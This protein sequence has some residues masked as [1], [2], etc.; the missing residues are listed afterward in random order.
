LFSALGSD[1]VHETVSD[2]TVGN[3]PFFFRTGRLF[4]VKSDE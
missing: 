4:C 1:E 2:L 3:P